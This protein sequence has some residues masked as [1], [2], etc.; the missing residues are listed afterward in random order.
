MYSQMTEQFQN[1]MKPFADLMSLNVKTME[2]LVANHADFLKSSYEDSVAYGK[3]LTEQK[4]IVSFFAAQRAYGE[5]FQ[6]KA[7]EAGREAYDVLNDAREESTEIVKSAF[8]ASVAQAKA[9]VDLVKP[10]AKKAAKTA[11]KSAK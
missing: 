6:A 2:T 1:S 8:S 7:I 3:S 10:A 9:N 4:D 11:A 5:E